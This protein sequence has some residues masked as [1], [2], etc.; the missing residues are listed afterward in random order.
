MRAQHFG[1]HF[2]GGLY[3]HAH[4]KRGRSNKEK[5]ATGNV[6]SF[7]EVFAF[8]S[9]KINGAEAQRDAQA[10][11]LEMSAFRRGHFVFC[12]CSGE[13]ARADDKS[14]NP[15]SITRGGVVKRYEGVRMGY[16]VRLPARGA[17]TGCPES[18]KK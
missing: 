13:G 16:E 15:K 3:G 18:A 2:D 1:G 6:Q 10:I 7:G 12:A 11:A 8:I 14:L 17:V 9:G 4:L 5:S